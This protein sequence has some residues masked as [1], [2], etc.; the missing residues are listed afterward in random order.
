M[1]FLSRKKRQSVVI[2]HKG[3]RLIVSLAEI[4]GDK[5][6]I[7]FD[8]PATFTVHREEIQQRID[9]MPKVETVWGTVDIGGGK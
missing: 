1:L 8:G 4:R 5:A 9:A 3:E 6:R 2:E 7:G